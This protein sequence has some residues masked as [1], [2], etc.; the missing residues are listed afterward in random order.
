M[1]SKLSTTVF[2]VILLAVCSVIAVTRKM[3]HIPTGTWGG[4]HIQ[5]KVGAKSA[6]IEYDC[7]SGVIQGPLVVDSDG[8]FNLRGTHRMQRGGPTRADETPNDH[9]ATYTGSIKGNTMTLNLKISDA[10]EETFTLEK[11]KEGELFRCK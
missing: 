7:A 6:T 5:M 3:Q 9:P 11:G 4:Q 2:V 1:F 8:N 10:D